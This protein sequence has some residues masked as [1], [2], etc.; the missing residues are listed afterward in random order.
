MVSQYD[1]VDAVAV[2]RARL[3]PIVDNQSLGKVVAANRP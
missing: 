1:A 3:S 2:H